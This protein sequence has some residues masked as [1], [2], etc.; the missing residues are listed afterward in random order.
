[1]VFVDEIYV[2][3]ADGSNLTRLTHNT[4]DDDDKSPF[5]SPDGSKIA[6]LSDRDEIFVY[7][8]YTMDADGSNQT[9]LTNNPGQSVSCFE[10]SP[11]GSK[12]DSLV[13]TR[14]E[15]VSAIQHI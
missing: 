1:M 12:I 9:R 15:E 8:L 5:W 11:G 7:Q 3:D 2:M 13:K 6:F 14:F 10:W 4:L